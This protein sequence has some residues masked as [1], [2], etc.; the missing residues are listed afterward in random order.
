MTS[1]SALVKD[2]FTSFESSSYPGSKIIKISQK[3]QINIVLC[4]TNFFELFRSILTTILMNIARK[5]L[6]KVFGKEFLA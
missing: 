3:S 4:N 2:L 1:S 5:T 6:T